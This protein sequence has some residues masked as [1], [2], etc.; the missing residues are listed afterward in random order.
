MFTHSTAA[1]Y[2]G[3]ATHSINGNCI[4]GLRSDGQLITRLPRRRH[5]IYEYPMDP[6]ANDLDLVTRIAATENVSCAC[7]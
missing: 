5:W 4:A 1:T 6:E 7:G 3:A 2:A